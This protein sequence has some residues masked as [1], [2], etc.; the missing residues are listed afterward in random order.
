MK[1][2]NL[3]Q[4]QF[5]PMPPPRSVFAP[6][7]VDVPDRRRSIFRDFITECGLWPIEPSTGSN[8]KTRYARNGSRRA[9]EPEG[10]RGANSSQSRTF[11]ASG[12]G[13]R[14]GSPGSG[15]ARLG[16][17]AKPVA[18]CFKIIICDEP[19]EL[20]V[21]EETDP[22]PGIEVRPGERRPRRP[23]GSL[24]I[25]VSDSFRSAKVSDK[26]GTLVE[27]KLSQFF[28]KAIALAQEVHARNE[29]RAASKRAYELKEKRRREIEQG[30]RAP[31]SQHGSVATRR[32]DQGL[33]AGNGRRAVPKGGPIDPESDA[34]KWLAW[35]RRH[36]DSLDPTHGPITIT[37]QEFWEWDLV[38]YNE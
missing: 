8:Q 28:G 31:E 13:L 7:R 15:Y 36:A 4:R 14:R 11:V 32:A 1:A 10:R 26:R 18:P 25:S 23:A 35:A 24:T 20:A 6:P 2:R 21:T 30:G 22:I 27:S 19:L 9:G 38:L 16:H 12:Q 37:Q 17:S 3:A 5:R 34:A 29:E 33:R